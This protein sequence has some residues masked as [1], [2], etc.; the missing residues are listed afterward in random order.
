M[1]QIWT[2]ITTLAKGVKQGVNQYITNDLENYVPFFIFAAV[3]L[4]GSQLWKLIQ[5]FKNK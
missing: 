4:V 2:F 3:V 1:E 5:K